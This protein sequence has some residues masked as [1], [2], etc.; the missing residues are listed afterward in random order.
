ME[1]RTCVSPSGLSISSK[2]KSRR[3]SK[4]NMAFFLDATGVSF[5]IAVEWIIPQRNEEQQVRT[6]EV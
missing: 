2:V 1:Q 6:R 5:R 4:L 3:D